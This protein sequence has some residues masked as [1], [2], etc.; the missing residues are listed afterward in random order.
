[1]A[2]LMKHHPQNCKRLLHYLRG[3]SSSKEEQVEEEKEK[4]KENEKV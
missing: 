1:M 4:K 2:Y 3:S